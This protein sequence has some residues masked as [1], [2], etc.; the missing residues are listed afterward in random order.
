MAH[1]AALYTDAERRTSPAWNEA[2]AHSHT[3]DGL[4]VRLDGPGGSRIAWVVGNPAGGDGWSSA[5]V[6]AVE[7][8]LPHLRQFVRVRQ[9]LVDARAL[10]ASALDLLGN[11][12]MGVS[13]RSRSG[14]GARRLPSSD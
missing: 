10:G 3:K 5:R 14:T 7:R 6:G 1:A 12:R 9:A 4:N 11:D 13:W 8:L 2:L